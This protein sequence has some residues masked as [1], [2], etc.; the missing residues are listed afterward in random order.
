MKNYLKNP[1]LINGNLQII[2]CAGAGK[3]EFVSEK[4]A[5]QVFKGIAKPDQIAAFTFTDKAAEE[6]K[7]R[8][9]SKIKTLIG[10]QTDIG[11]I[12]IGT[13]HSRLM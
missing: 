5:Y 7:F 8:V 3:T 11:D 6:L 9:R 12:Y 13:I 10:K 4:I 2:A 1:Q